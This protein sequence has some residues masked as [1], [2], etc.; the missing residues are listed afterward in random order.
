MRQSDP[1]L[2]IVEPEPPGEFIREILMPPLV[3][4]LPEGR[5]YAKI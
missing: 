4:V 1:S 5:T 2:T 3:Y